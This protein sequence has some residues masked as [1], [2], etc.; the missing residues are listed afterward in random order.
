MIT[1]QAAGLASLSPQNAKSARR[2]QQKAITEGAAPAMQEKLATA[3]IDTELRIAHF[4]AQTCEESDGFC[5][6]E[7]YASGEAYQGRVDL[8]NAH[9]GDGVRFKGRGLIMIT[10]RYNYTQYGKLLGLPLVDKPTL[11]AD[12]VNAVSIAIAYWSEHGL[13]AFADKD[14]IETITRRINGG[15]NGL[16]TRQIYLIR[17]MRLVTPLVPP[18]EVVA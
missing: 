13:N 14:D 4:L 2:V 8:G 10:G 9:P 18:T 3:G 12:P 17:A 6:T 15:L 11:A 1:I 5:T 16:A 7:E